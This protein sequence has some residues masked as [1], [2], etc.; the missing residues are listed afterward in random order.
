MKE[1]YFKNNEFIIENYDKQRVFTSYLPAIAGKNGI[2][3]WAFY[4]NRGQIMSSF[5]VKDKNGAILE[6]FP[7]YT[8]YEVINRIANNYLDALLNDE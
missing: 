7:A 3:M 2:P 1:Y 6:F 5:G 8:A 4:V